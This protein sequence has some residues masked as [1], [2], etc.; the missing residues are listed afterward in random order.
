M[1]SAKYEL[2]PIPAGESPIPLADVQPEDAGNL[3]ASWL[4]RRVKARRWAAMLP[5][6]GRAALDD[7]SDMDPTMGD[8]PVA[9]RPAE[10]DAAIAEASASVA[11][12]RSR[13]GARL[14][15]TTAPGQERRSRQLAN[16][17]VGS[18]N[19]TI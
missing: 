2:P 9:E 3:K 13:T 19:A 18:N 1:S 7:L 11:Q 8:G 14:T 12:A 10:S 16:V 6:A 5:A 17:F 4:V 15:T